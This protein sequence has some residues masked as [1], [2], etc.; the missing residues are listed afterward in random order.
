MPAAHAR[1]SL[2]IQLYP[3]LK[4]TLKCTLHFSIVGRARSDCISDREGTEIW[5][6]VVAY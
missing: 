5:R 1:L 3:R 4:I 2:K 6:A